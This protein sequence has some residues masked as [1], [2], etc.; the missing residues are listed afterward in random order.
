MAR[1][2]KTKRGGAGRGKGAIGA[3]EKADIS[4]MRALLEQDLRLDQVALNKALD[5]ALTAW[6]KKTQEKKR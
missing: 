6:A 3:K 4:R 1:Q 5:D 2:G